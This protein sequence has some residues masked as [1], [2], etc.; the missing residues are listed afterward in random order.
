MGDSGWQAEVREQLL[1]HTNPKKVD[2]VIDDLFL[3]YPTPEALAD[4]REDELRSLLFPLGMA[5]TRARHLIQFA[6]EYT[7][8]SSEY[9]C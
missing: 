4:A 5:R 1:V 3:D 7:P 2:L 6:R 8:T 9:P